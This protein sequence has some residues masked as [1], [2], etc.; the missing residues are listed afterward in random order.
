MLSLFQF[1]KQCDRVLFLKDGRLV[2]QGSHTELMELA[3]GHY[4]QI[5]EFD[6]HR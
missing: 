5:A 3:S 2:E 4:R 1:L 6:A